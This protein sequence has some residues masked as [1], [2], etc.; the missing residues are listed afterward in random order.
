MQMKVIA[1]ISGPMKPVERL[2]ACS[3]GI[4][5]LLASYVPLWNINLRSPQYPE[6]LHLVISPQ[7]LTGNVQSVNILNHYI[8]MKPLSDA[9]FPEFSWMM[10]WIL[11]IGMVLL[12]VAMIGR[13]EVALPGRLLLFGFDGYMLWDLYHWLY[14]WGHNLDPRAPITVAPFTPPLFGFERIANFLVLSYPSW[15]G[16]CVMTASFLMGYTLWYAARRS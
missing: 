1:A 8:G 16:A 5:M 13:R 15:G 7:H 12:V 10:P 6:G 4:L 14:N 3:T 9:A 2:L 11:S